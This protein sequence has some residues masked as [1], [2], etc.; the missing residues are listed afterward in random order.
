MLGW[1]ELGSERCLMTNFERIKNMDYYQMIEFLLSVE[2]NQYNFTHS[3]NVASWLNVDIDLSK[4]K[5]C[6]SYE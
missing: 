6:K 5:V 3:R 4:K 1:G 2:L